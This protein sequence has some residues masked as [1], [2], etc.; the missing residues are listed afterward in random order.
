MNVWVTSE[1]NSYGLATERW[2]D[3]AIEHPAISFANS[4]GNLIDENIPGAYPYSYQTCIKI[5]GVTEYQNMMSHCLM[6]S[7]YNC[8]AARFVH[9][10]TRQKCSWNHK[11]PNE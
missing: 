3:G 6:D 11:K 8:L 10:S 9:S 2:F 4:D 7:Y 5:V 1:E